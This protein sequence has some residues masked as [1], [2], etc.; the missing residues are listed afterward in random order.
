ML[1]PRASAAGRYG[2]APTTQ[3]PL[4]LRMPDVRHHSEIPHV[5]QGLAPVHRMSVE[6]PGCEVP[7]QKMGC[8]IRS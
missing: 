6:E 5:V 4:R 7:V 8:E 1:S 2:G 3:L